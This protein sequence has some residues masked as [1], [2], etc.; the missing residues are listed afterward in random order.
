MTVS[1]FESVPS[2][3]AFTQS[4]ALDAVAHNASDAFSSVLMA[5][6]FKPEWVRELRDRLDSFRNLPQNWDSYGACRP[7]IASLQLAKQLLDVIGE[8]VGVDP[9]RIGTSSAG[10]AA[11]SWELANGRNLDLEVLPSGSMRFAFWCDDDD[12]HDDEGTT[13]Y[14]DKIASFLTQWQVK[15]NDC[16]RNNRR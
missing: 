3:V 5:S 14:V 10:N 8:V 2:G 16:G 13:E 1:M 12:S 11:F 7:S 6:R 15:P 9:P 4:C